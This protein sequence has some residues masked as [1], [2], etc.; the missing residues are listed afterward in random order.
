[1]ISRPNHESEDDDPHRE[2]AND[3]KALRYG[4]PKRSIGML[5]AL[6]NQGSV[7]AVNYLAWAY[8]HGSGVPADAQRAITLYKQAEDQGSLDA[9]V[10]LASLY[11]MRQDWAQA[12]AALER[13]RERGSR[14]CADR[15]KELERTECETGE[16]VLL[17]AALAISK[18]DATK[19]FR[20]LR[21]LAE[22]GL[23]QAMLY[24]GEA[25]HKGKGARVDYAWAEQWYERA[26]Q[27]GGCTTKAHAA[28]GL[29]WLYR[30]TGDPVRAYEAYQCGA[31]Y[32]NAS[33]FR[34]LAAMRQ[35]G[36]GC[37]Q[38]IN[39]A[40]AL[41]EKGADTGNVFASADLAR[42][43]ISGHWGWRSRIAGFLLY[44]RTRWSAFSIALRNP[45]E[46]RLRQ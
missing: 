40:R 27:G 2:V 20:E 11:G 13:G 39:T 17:Q 19:G 7:V 32:G 22:R 46:S 1:M 6:A 18:A 26:Y 44:W 4:N 28:Y 12:R 33:C 10:Y 3:A 24:L 29:G 36:L 31:D 34:M 30:E 9:P 15:L 5:Q 37:K 41:L 43:L 35:Q 23:T 14:V 42:L 8:E 38:D 16:W 21:G 25:Y 45:K